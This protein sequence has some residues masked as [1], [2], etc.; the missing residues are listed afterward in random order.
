MFKRYLIAGLLVWIPLAITFWVLD[1]IVSTMDQTLLL[2][3]T[4][5]RP[6][7]LLQ[8]HV[9]GIGLLLSLLIV[10]VTGV[11]AANIIG[12]RLLRWWH[13]LL[14]RIP[15]VR[16]IYSSVKQISDTLLATR[17]QSFRKVV[18][19]EFPQRGQ[20]TLGFVVGSPGAT[21]AAATA[22]DAITVYVPTAPNPTSGYVLV[23]R[24]DDV[25]E[26][27]ISVDDALKFHIS[28]G[29]VP[30][31][32]SARVPRSAVSNQLT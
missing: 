13:G 26:V 2:L 18:M 23:V 17:G 1:L 22:V 7:T 24:P 5:W 19:I 30:P 20:W 9:P 25:R 10:L 4:N 32:V 15:I 29:V 27:D 12:E 8:F 21:I 11:L 31:R 14:N 28:L 3:P 16:S 6:D